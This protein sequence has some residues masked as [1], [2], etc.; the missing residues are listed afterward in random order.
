MQQSRITGIHITTTCLIILLAVNSCVH[1]LKH[2]YS[3]AT[4]RLARRQLAL[5]TSI[6]PAVERPNCRSLALEYADYTFTKFLYLLLDEIAGADVHL[7]I[8]HTI[9]CRSHIAAECLWIYVM[10]PSDDTSFQL[11]FEYMQRCTR[12]RSGKTR[13]LLT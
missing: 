3:G 10:L 8:D 13:S 6:S 12:R 4:L 5:F 9:S 2:V 7:F 11:S 1:A